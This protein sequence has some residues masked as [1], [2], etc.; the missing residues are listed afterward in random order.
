MGFACKRVRHRARRDRDQNHNTI[1][2]CA[3]EC[4]DRSPDSILLETVC[5]QQY[6]N[7]TDQYMR[8]IINE[9]LTQTNAI[10]TSQLRDDR[11]D[12]IDDS[13]ENMDDENMVERNKKIEKSIPSHRC[14][15]LAPI[16]VDQLKCGRDSN[17][18]QM[19]S[20]KSKTAI[21]CRCECEIMSK[22][23]AIFA[24]PFW[25]AGTNT[26]SRFIHMINFKRKINNHHRIFTLPPSHTEL[27]TIAPTK[28]H[29]NNN[30]NKNQNKISNKSERESKSRSS[31]LNSIVHNNNHSSSS[32]KCDDIY[33][34]GHNNRSI[35]MSSQC[36]IR[37]SVCLYAASG[38]LIALCFLATPA[39]ASIDSLHPM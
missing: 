13:L 5:R 33:N 31:N 32:K 12:I 17:E 15:S 4:V 23:S 37:Q 20:S 30:N 7:T 18:H 8:R 21:V 28:L 14:E 19:S 6:D 22:F 26:I 39:T 10:T 27:E 24:A 1:S 9:K 35:I 38:F 25:F 29:T 2:Y 34:R 16:M 11:D 36:F 3:T